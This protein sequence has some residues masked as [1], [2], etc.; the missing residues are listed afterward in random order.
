MTGAPASIVLALTALALAACGSRMFHACW[1]GTS[2]TRYEYALEPRFVGQRCG[3]E[4][5]THAHLADD[6]GAYCV[7]NE[8]AAARA[9]SPCT[10]SG[11]RLRAGRPWPLAPGLYSSG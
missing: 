2:C 6:G 10:L 4:G 7:R 8:S 11:R 1:P 5:L 9:A 3:D